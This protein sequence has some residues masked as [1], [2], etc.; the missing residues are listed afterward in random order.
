MSLSV[1]LSSIHEQ[2]VW[3]HIIVVFSFSSILH[4]VMDWLI[5]IRGGEGSPEN[6]NLNFNKDLY[7]KT[8]LAVV[9]YIVQSSFGTQSNHL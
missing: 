8:N 5:G 7:F 4:K 9:D 3:T 1:K 2:S 6:R